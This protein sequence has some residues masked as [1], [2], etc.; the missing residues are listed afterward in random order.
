VFEGALVNASSLGLVSLFGS[1]ISHVRSSHNT[2]TLC[3][4]HDHHLSSMASPTLQKIY[5][6]QVH[7]NGGGG[8]GG[9]RRVEKRAASN[10]EPSDMALD[11]NQQLISRNQRARVTRYLQ[12]V[13]C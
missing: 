8:S 5:S 10:R 12:R 6:E 11:V 13:G 7:S 9:E 4:H 3:L 2:T 1:I